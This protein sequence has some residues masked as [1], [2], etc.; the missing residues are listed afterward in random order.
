[1]D[2]IVLLVSPKQMRN[3]SP[4]MSRQVEVHLLQRALEGYH[5]ETADY[6]QGKKMPCKKTNDL[7]ITHGRAIK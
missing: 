6:S 5:Q 7:F 3:D 2:S 4:V 1:M